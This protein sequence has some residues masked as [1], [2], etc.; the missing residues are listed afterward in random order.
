MKKEKLEGVQKRG[1]RG[2]REGGQKVGRSRGESRRG[3][4]SSVPL[5]HTHTL[6]SLIISCILQ[7]CNF[8]NNHTNC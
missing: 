8:Y 3:R 6:C 4:G 5:L 7:K 1:G 2:K